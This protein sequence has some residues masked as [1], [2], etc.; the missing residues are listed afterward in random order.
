M[1]KNV[2]LSIAIMYLVLLALAF[3]PAVNSVSGGYSLF[4]FLIGTPLRDASANFGVIVTTTNAV[5]LQALPIFIVLV[6]LALLVLT[7]VPQIDVPDIYV[8]IITCVMLFFYSFWLGVIVFALGESG[9]GIASIISVLLY[10][11]AA[12]IAVFSGSKAEEKSF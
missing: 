6:S 1:K 5:T 11:A 4:D 2:K 7:L 12:I 8:K 3:I 9:F 10:L